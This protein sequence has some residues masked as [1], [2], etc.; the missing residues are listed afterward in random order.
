MRISSDDIDAIG[1][2]GIISKI[3]AW[4]GSSKPVYFSVDIDILDPAQAPGIG[5]PEVG[6]WTSRELIQ[7]LRGVE[8]L[9]VIGADIVEVSPQWDNAGQMTALVAS[10]ILYEILTSISKRGSLQTEEVGSGKH[11]V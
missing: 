10:Q 5:T 7:I 4:I 9:N 8:G 1:A 2:K 6:G 3:N 11:E